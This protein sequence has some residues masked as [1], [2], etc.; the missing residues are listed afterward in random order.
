MSKKLMY[1]ALSV[2]AAASLA[3]SGCSPSAA[4]P[5]PS[6]SAAVATPASASAAL[7]VNQPWVKA[8][9]SGM[10]GG[11]G[12]I[13][14]TSDADITVTGASTPAARMVELHETVA[15]PDGAM[16]MRSK[17]GGFV[18]PAGGELILE[19]GASHLMLMGLT[20]P[21]VAGSDVTF[22]LELAGGGSFEFT[23]VAK[24]FSGAN[25]NY[26]DEGGAGR[27]HGQPSGAAGSATPSAPSPTS[28]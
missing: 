11:F 26:V 5:V 17:E 9:A 15:G 27:S 25:E 13:K 23:T 19:P 18:I 1:P 22:T 8:A 7:A 21:I 12:V 24:D 6:A 16:Q 2:L 4:T 10:T 14:N 20:A 28:K 3:L